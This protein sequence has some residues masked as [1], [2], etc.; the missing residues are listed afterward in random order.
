MA[1]YNSND[2][3]DAFLSNVTEQDIDAVVTASHDFDE[4]VQENLGNVQKHLEAAIHGVIEVTKQAPVGSNSLSTFDN[5]HGSFD[6]GELVVDDSDQGQ[7]DLEATIQDAVKTAVHE[8]LETSIHSARGTTTQGA[9]GITTQN[10][11]EITNQDTFGPNMVPIYSNNEA[12]SLGVDIYDSS[13]SLEP[14]I[15]EARYQLEQAEQT[16]AASVLH[17]SRGYLCDFVRHLP[18]EAQTLGA[19]VTLSNQFASVHRVLVNGQWTNMVFDMPVDY[20]FGD[21]PIVMRHRR[22]PKRIRKHLQKAREARRVQ[23]A[24]ASSPANRKGGSTRPTSNSVALGIRPPVATQEQ[25][26]TVE[27]C[28]ASSSAMPHT[29][30]ASLSSSV[31]M[32][33]VF[34]NGNSNFI[35]EIADYL[36]DASYF[37]GVDDSSASEDEESAC[38]ADDDGHFTSGEYEA[39]SLDN[40]AACALEVENLFTPEHDFFISNN[41]GHPV[42]EHTP[43]DDSLGAYIWEENADH[44]T[45]YDVVTPPPRFTAAES[46]TSSHSYG[47]TETIAS[48]PFTPVSAPFTPYTPPS[49][50]STTTTPATPATPATPTKVGDRRAKVASTRATPK[51]KVASLGCGECPAV[52]ATKNEQREHVNTQ[53]ARVFRCY[54]NWA[55]C[56]ATFGTKNEWK[57]HCNTQHVRFD[58]WACPATECVAGKDEGAGVMGGV[59]HRKDLFACH[60]RRQHGNQEV[61]DINEAAMSSKTKGVYPAWWVAAEAAMCAKA[62]FRRIEMKDSYRCPLASCQVSFSGGGGWDELLEH[63]A[64]HMKTIRAE[65][66]RPMLT[67]GLADPEFTEWAEINNVV[68]REEHSSGY[69]SWR[70]PVN[71]SPQSGR[72]GKNGAAAMAAA[73]EM[74]QQSR[75]ARESPRTPL[76]QLVA[77]GFVAKY[78]CL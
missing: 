70:L 14:G 47:L 72:G 45:H 18:Q 58:L 76:R 26:T 29:A 7:I 62:L 28:N 4:P 68:V 1:Y 41:N 55:G 44:Y 16:Q 78:S 64:G 10:S 66:G 52:F 71:A 37:S 51:A 21:S 11:L 54:F 35:P 5:N 53:H 15:E 24:P 67:G 32:S 46:F 40:Y 60:A 17:S 2:A 6:L 42:S 63:V 48:S 49:L 25:A 75:L 9:L 74:W 3:L 61:R 30:L 43:T 23:L 20:N 34:Y 31:G 36:S 8:I 65:G 77:N 39:V 22:N 38:S 13:G 73:N 33:N 27:P 69:V 59:F 50:A 57:R 19:A 12:A 56:T